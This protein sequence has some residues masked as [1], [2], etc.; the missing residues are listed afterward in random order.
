[1]AIGKLSDPKI[2][3][4][5]Y[6]FYSL[7]T[8]IKNFN[9]QRMVTQNIFPYSQKNFTYVLLIKLNL[10]DSSVDSNVGKLDFLEIR[11]KAKFR[12]KSK[13]NMNR[14]KLIAEFLINHNCLKI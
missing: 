7:C 10:N 14:L 9:A 2:P 11:I 8:L 6:V 13:I 1:M 12:F 5:K 4:K 3:P